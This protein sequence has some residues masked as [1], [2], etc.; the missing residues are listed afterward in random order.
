VESVRVSGISPDGRRET[1]G[2]YWKDC[3]KGFKPAAKEYRGGY[4]D[5]ESDNR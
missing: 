5:G 3:E 1:I 4:M 2:P